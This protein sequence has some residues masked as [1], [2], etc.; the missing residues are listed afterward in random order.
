MP[1]DASIALGYRQNN[2][3]PSI[4]DKV[5]K[6][7]SLRQM[8]ED[9]TTR[10]QVREQQLK[11]GEQNLQAGEQEITLNRMKMD[12]GQ[13]SLQ[14]QQT[15]MKIIA[16]HNGDI[17][18]ALPKLSGA[19]DPESFL[20]IAKGAA[21]RA[22]SLVALKKDKFDLAEKQNGQLMTLLEQTYELPD[23]QLLAA[24][25]TVMARALQIDPNFQIPEQPLSRDQMHVLGLGLLSSEQDFKRAAERRAKELHGPAVAKATADAIH[26]EQ[27]AQ[28]TVP[29]TPFQQ[30]QVDRQALPNTPA[31]L[32]IV[33]NDPKRTP[34]ER[35]VAKKALLEL[36]RHA[37]AG[38]PVVNAG[39]TFT[40][41]AIN[42]MAQ[43]YGQTGQ[44]P[45]LGNGA[46]GTQARVA[47]VNKAAEIDPNQNVAANKATFQAD[48]QSLAVLQKSRDA[49]V[50]FEHTATKNLDLFLAQSKQII[51]S[52][53]PWLNQPVRKVT[54]QMVGDDNFLAF[55]A[56]RR[57][58]V[59]EIAKITSNPSL[60]GQ[61]SDSA[62]HEVESFIPEDATLKEIYGVAKVLKKDMENRRI[63]LDR[64]IGEIKGRLTGGG[65]QPAATATPS[66]GSKA[67]L[68][69]NPAT[70]MV[71]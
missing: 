28:G 64:Q 50:A 13:R 65:A 15:A 27:V 58:A 16:E 22:K 69:Y 40:P 53:M 18:A 47:V 20:A 70:G 54:R 49:V 60:T 2:E 44:M 45:A 66:S 5:G 61:L 31:E 8:M 46:A 71:E 7:I 14:S 6:M 39:G 36:E 62:R 32:A 55:Q 4:L 26:A 43:F 34:E 12:A 11:I 21:E 30:A 1:I 57:V 42:L 19:I 17:E 35:G 25:P 38:R 48:S 33:A 37:R 41:E 52:G 10:A 23:E 29:I 56:A 63:E 51:D 24:W 9:S 68:K 3:T 59:N 67:R